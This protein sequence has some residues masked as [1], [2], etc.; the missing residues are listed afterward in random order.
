MSYNPLDSVVEDV[1]T[2]SSGEYFQ[3]LYNSQTESYSVVKRQ[4][5]FGSPEVIDE[6]I[7]NKEDA[8][9]L[10]NS[11]ESKTLEE[12]QAALGDKDGE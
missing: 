11:E 8:Q 12:L 9:E 4:A 7:A 10:L 5:R 3:L 6:D 1:Y 2:N